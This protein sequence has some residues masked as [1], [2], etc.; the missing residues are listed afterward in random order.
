MHSSTGVLPCLKDLPWLPFSHRRK[1]TCLSSVSRA[2][3]GQTSVYLS[4]TPSHKL[5]LPALKPVLSLEVF[6]DPDYFPFL[7]CL[8]SSRQSSKK[9]HFRELFFLS[10]SPH[11]LCLDLCCNPLCNLLVVTYMCLCLLLVWEPLQDGDL[12]L[13]LLSLIQA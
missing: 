9:F 8:S 7:E 13:L 10:L 6:V 4:M 3:Q 12:I 1:A 5:S 11:G 2:L